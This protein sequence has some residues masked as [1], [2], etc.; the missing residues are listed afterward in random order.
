MLLTRAAVDTPVT[1]AA[2]D[3]DSQRQSRWHG[4]AIGGSRRASGG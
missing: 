4:S 2:Q 1:Q 3:N